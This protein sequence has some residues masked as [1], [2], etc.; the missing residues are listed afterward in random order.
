MNNKMKKDNLSDDRILNTLQELATKEEEDVQTIYHFLT[1]TFFSPKSVHD[2]FGKIMNAYLEQSV[3]QTNR[4][5]LNKLVFCFMEKTIQKS[6]WKEF[7]YD[8]RGSW[9]LQRLL[10]VMTVN[11]MTDEYV[12]VI[13]AYV[14]Q[15]IAQHKLKAAKIVAI[16]STFF[17]FMCKPLADVPRSKY[18]IRHYDETFRWCWF[19]MAIELLLELPDDAFIKVVEPLDWDHYTSLA[20]DEI[21]LKCMGSI[22]AINAANRWIELPMVLQKVILRQARFR[23]PKWTDRIEKSKKGIHNLVINMITQMY[24]K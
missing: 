21:Q 6:L 2:R 13:H 5:D 22:P 23:N 19:M 14:S 20:M 24:D 8:K 7:T 10:K 11:R 16:L 18:N 4:N 3:N 15:Y 12:Q 1:N 9:L 17:K